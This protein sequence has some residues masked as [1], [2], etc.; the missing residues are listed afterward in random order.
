MPRF[1][2]CDR[3]RG[4]RDWA[5]MKKAALRARTEV[6]SVSFLPAGRKRLGVVVSREVGN[7]VVRNRIKRVVREHFRTKRELFPRGDTAVIA[8]QRAA[9]LENKELRAELE[10][11]VKKIGAI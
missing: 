4:V 3:I 2:K 9:H 6:F 5:R 7:A 1:Q 11:V 8:R 10:R